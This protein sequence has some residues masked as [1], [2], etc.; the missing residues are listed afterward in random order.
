MQGT[1]EMNIIVRPTGILIEDNRFL[2]VR[3]HV[4]ETRGWSMPGGKL[5][6]GET[7]EWCLIREIKE[8]TGLDIAVKELLYM[9]DRLRS[10][11]THVVHMTFLVERT[12]KKPVEFE[13]TH[14]DPHISVSSKPMRE[15]KMVPIDELTDYGFSITFQNLVKTG[16]PERG[17]YQ[18]D[19]YTFYGELPSDER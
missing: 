4:T 10:S 14:H 2:L 12:G 15:I 18:G 16:F 13:W 6:S 1:G 5:E 11:D 3:Q 17:S 7:L 8:E 9:T 19:F